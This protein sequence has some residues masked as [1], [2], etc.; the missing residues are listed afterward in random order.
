MKKPDD[1]Y[2]RL[3]ET[4]YN[5]IIRLRAELAAISKA[6]D[7]PRTDLTLTMVE[8]IQ[9]IRAELEAEKEISAALTFDRDSYRNE[10]RKLR[11]IE[12][13]A[14]NLIAV[15]GRHHTEQAFKALEEVL[16]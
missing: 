8:V 16:K 4:R 7:D 9:E 12:A 11:D 5:E 6:L 1:H 2:Q 10:N 14:K 15:K 13:A 3:C